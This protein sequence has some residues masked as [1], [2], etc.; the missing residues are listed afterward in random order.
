MAAARVEIIAQVSSR[1]LV[2][3]LPEKP[4]LSFVPVLRRRGFL[5]AET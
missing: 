5:P 4:L 1:A 2:E 3:A